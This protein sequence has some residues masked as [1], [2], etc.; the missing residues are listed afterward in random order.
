MQIIS[1]YITH[2]LFR[3]AF[4]YTVSEIIVSA[5]PFFLLPI[6]TRYLTPNEYGIIATFQILFTIIAGFVLLDIHGVISVNYFKLDILQ[7]RIYI[8]NVAFI[9][10]INFV[11][12]LIV[13][14]LLKSPLSNLIKFPE[15]WLPNIVI[16]A[17]FQ[18]IITIGLTLWQVEQNPLIYGIFQI[19][20]T[21]INV[22]L[23]LI[24]IVWF[25]WGWEGR[26]YGIMISSI[27]FGVIAIIRMRRYVKFSL[28][29]KYIYDALHFCIPLIPHTLGGLLMLAT[30][31]LLINVMVNVAET[32]IY[33]VGYQVGMVIN[34]L[35][36][37]FNKAWAPFLFE[38]LKENNY[39]TKI[40]I[41]KFTYLYLAAITLLAI[42]LTCAA[43]EIL[44]FLVSSNFRS[45]D[46]YVLWIAAGYAANGMYFMVVNYIFYAKKTFILAWITLLASIVNAVLCY[47]LIKKNGP[48]GAAQA[49]TISNFVIFSLSW[50]LSAKVYKMPWA[51]KYANKF[52]KQRN[53]Y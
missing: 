35:A 27:A 47:F 49:M 10:I 26:L 16:I 23:S 28:K 20:H 43:P 14:S 50:L 8:G 41:V 52:S 1:N 44:S 30:G 22:L 32:G 15:N 11:I 12:F 34:L 9:I 33:T 31:R 4:I 21:T 48:V 7:L 53:G 3:N 29:R 46:K 2:K 5:V 36:A 17:L 39:E 37:S 45:A 18:A 24:F 13:S 51:L 25:K 42:L 40:K 38:K 19:S 6:L